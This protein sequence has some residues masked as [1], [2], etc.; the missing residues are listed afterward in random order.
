[1]PLLIAGYLVAWCLSYVYMMRSR[2]DQ[3]EWRECYDYFVLAWTFEAGEIP[4]F[5]W[6]YSLVVFVLMAGVSISLF[7][8]YR[9]F[10]SH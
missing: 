6:G 9:K 5:I 10:K 4:A 8:I 7:F 3:P 2:G 1:M